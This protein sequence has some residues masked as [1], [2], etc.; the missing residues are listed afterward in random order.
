VVR[1]AA[2]FLAKQGNQF[3]NLAHSAL[4]NISSVIPL[5][6]SIWQRASGVCNRLAMKRRTL[7]R[8]T[9]LPKA[10]GQDGGDA[11]RTFCQR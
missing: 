1:R 10:D 5:E 7:R 6:V 2:V 3:V 9:A 11:A 8:H 4:S